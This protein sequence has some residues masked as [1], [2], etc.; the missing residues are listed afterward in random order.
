MVARIIHF[1]TD[2]CRRLLVL[3][4]AGFAVEECPS[5][6]LLR[7]ALEDDTQPLAVVISENRLR[8]TSDAVELV[9]AHTGAP[10]ILFQ[11]MIQSYN[12]SDFDLVVPVLT[13]PGEWLYTV[14]GLI[15]RAKSS[16]PI[17]RANADANQ[18]LLT[19]TPDAEID[20]PRPHARPHR[21][22]RTLRH[23]A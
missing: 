1:G 6:P 13:Y 17:V 19:S 11:N 15:D 10:L 22:V 2:E 21:P 3:R 23:K 5:L 16:F 8:I 14:L 18:P 7:S 12:E 9:R 4:S 20:I